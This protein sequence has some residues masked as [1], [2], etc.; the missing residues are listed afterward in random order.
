MKQRIDQLKEKGKS[1]ELIDRL[2]GVA[3]NLAEIR[4]DVQDQSHKARPFVNEYHRRHNEPVKALEKSLAT[5]DRCFENTTKKLDE[6]D[7]AVRDLLQFASCLT[8]STKRPHADNLQ[9]F[10]W[11]SINESFKSTSTATSAKRLS[12]VTVRVSLL[13]KHVG[14][15]HYSLFSSLLCLPR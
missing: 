10:A 3:K 15:H 1:S 6:L 8:V 9:E 4:N 12:W 14:T 2:A 11:V 13:M 7:Q 5:V